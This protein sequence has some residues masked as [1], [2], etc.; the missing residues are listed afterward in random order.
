MTD[1]GASA[2]KKGLEPKWL[3]LMAVMLGTIMGPLDALVGAPHSWR[4]GLKPEGKEIPVAFSAVRRW[5][6][7]CSWGRQ[8]KCEISSYG[9]PEA[10]PSI[11]I[12]S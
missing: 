5:D 2:T 10:G 3:I 4:L 6:I 1:I 7:R 12:L 9:L 8:L 11:T